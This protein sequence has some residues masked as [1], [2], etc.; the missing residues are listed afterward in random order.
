MR[1]FSVLF[2][3]VLIMV[4][5]S[6]SKDKKDV[7]MPVTSSEMYLSK[8]IGCMNHSKGL[9]GNMV[10]AADTAAARLVNGGRIFVTDDETLLLSGE[11]EERIIPGSDYTYNIHENSGGLVAEACD[12]AGGLIHIKPMS[13]KAELTDRDVVLVGTLELKP[14]EQLKQIRAYKD[15]GALIIVF[16]SRDARISGI[17]DYVI[18]NGLE[19]GL[20]PVISVGR[21]QTIAPVAGV[22]NVINMWVFTSELV[23]SLTRQGKMPA[24]WQSMFVPGS[25]VRNTPL[26]EF[27]FHP[28]MEIEPI[29][30]EILGRQYIT[31]VQSYLE[32]IKMNELEKFHKAGKMCA[33]TVS[34]GGKIILSVIGHFMPSQHR[35]P[36]FPDIFTVRVNEAAVGPVEGILEKGD[37]WLHAGYS[38][39]PENELTSLRKIGAQSICVF[40][41][42]PP[43]IGEGNPVA[44]DRDLMDI[45]IDPYWKHGD[46]VVEVPGYDI[47]IMPPS[48]VVMVA[49]YWMLIGETMAELSSYK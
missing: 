34:G 45:Y 37:V 47:K 3:M 16:G 35:M 39:Y 38:Y 30:A 25:G 31:V 20:V 29:E 17:A 28:G 11:D 4:F 13:P 2:P 21:E 9:L 33:E 44:I 19:P 22:A 23:A 36:G 42:G 24:V 41:P 32:K 6:C 46:A 12:R 14:D 26:G 10:K 7:S 15:D 40:T 48:G 49:C 18:D 8:V 1:W 5:F 27:M 43:Y